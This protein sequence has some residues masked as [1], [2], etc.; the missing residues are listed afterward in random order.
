MPCP[1]PAPVPRSDPIGVCRALARSS[2][3]AHIV[4][5][6]IGARRKAERIERENRAVIFRPAIRGLSCV[7]REAAR[8]C[9]LLGRIAIRYVRV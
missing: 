3:E 7:P 2:A 6:C 1:A 4:K 5:E 9:F 8:R